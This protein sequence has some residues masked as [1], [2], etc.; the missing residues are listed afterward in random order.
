M[1][2][3]EARAWLLQRKS[4]AAML[5]NL[6]CASSTNMWLVKR[7]R[8]GTVCP[9]WECCT[10]HTHSSKKYAWSGV[11]PAGPPTEHFLECVLVGIRTTEPF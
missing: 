10:W 9:R 4:C 7:A 8:P 11:V 1:I 3:E 6:D 2:T 5:H